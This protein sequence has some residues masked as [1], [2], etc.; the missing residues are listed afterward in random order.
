MGFIDNLNE[1]TVWGNTGTD[2]LYALLIF[3]VVI[4]ILKFFQAIVLMNLK[5]LSK[6]TQTDVDDLIV[7]VL[8][9]IHALFYIVIGVYVG[10]LHLSLSE[11]VNKVIQVI[12][13]VVVVYEI[14]RAAE[15][16]L[17]YALARYIK[18]RSAQDGKQDDDFNQ[19]VVKTLQV[20]IKIVLWSIGILM[21]LSNIG[22][23]ITSLV[24]SLGIGGI[25]IALAVQNILSDAFSSFSIYFD[26][27]FQVG[28]F[29]TLGNDMG[30]VERI[31]LKS[32]RIRT[33]QGEELV[34]SNQELTSARI[35]NFKKMEKR[36]VAFNV[37]IVYGTSKEKLRKIPEVVK[38]IIDEADGAEFDRCHFKS[39]G[40]S[41]LNYEIVYY[42][43]TSDYNK[44]MDINQEINLAIFDKFAASKI[45]FAY[46]TQTVFL[47]K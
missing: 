6:K 32:T 20:V 41:S 13:M 7:G 10:T 36:R 37:G 14:I 5:K 35:Q 18:H 4:I 8:D 16:L 2:Y 23:N 17:V 22:I 46:P 39:Y 31:G 45:E 40:D 9:K 42:V 33:L 24:A 30:T 1:W 11:A 27:P 44:Y 28:D 19:S 43:T 38:Q 26:K 3:I 34:V 12:F 47:N 25:A 21:I 29:I 15:R